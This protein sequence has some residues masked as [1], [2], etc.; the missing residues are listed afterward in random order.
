ML[1]LNSLDT[2]FVLFAF[3]IQTVLIIHFALRCWA[4]ETAVKYGPFVYALGIPAAALSMA[5]FVAGE[6]WYMWLGGVLFAIFGAFG[7][8]VEY[9]FDIEWRNPV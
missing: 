7:Y 3:L 2:L 5:Q 4:F 6:P 8:I 1:G 9:V